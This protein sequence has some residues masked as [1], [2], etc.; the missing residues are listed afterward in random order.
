M[1]FFL[2]SLK[3]ESSDWLFN[4]AEQM[5]LSKKGLPLCDEIAAYLTADMQ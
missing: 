3:F 5:G 4:N 2:T 1:R